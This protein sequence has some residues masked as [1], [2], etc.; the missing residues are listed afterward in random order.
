MAE[1]DD[2]RYI[3]RYERYDDSEEW[4]LIAICDT[5][6]EGVKLRDTEVAA[7]REELTEYFSHK[8]SDFIDFQTEYYSF[9][10]VEYPAN[11]LFDS[12]SARVVE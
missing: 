5:E 10:L 8:D 11:K 12:K 3:L 4:E 6:A 9:L 1:R 2:K 7:K